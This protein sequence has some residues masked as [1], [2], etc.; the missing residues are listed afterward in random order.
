MQKQP[1]AIEKSGAASVFSRI[2]EKMGPTSETTPV[3]F[4][5]CQVSHLQPAVAKSHET[6]ASGPGDRS[7]RREATF[8]E[9]CRRQ[10]EVHDDDTTT[11]RLHKQ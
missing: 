9:N 4:P 5:H 2:P 7:A 11:T 6:K 3:G 8:S 10:R 1:G